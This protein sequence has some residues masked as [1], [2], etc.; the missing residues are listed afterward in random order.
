MTCPPNTT[1]IT[2][3][4]AA[5]PTRSATVRLVRCRHSIIPPKT[6]MPAASAT[7]PPRDLLISKATR[8]MK[9][10]AVATTVRR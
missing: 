7:K 5:P 4:T 2:A 8:M 9:T 10:P 6:A 1:T 3:I